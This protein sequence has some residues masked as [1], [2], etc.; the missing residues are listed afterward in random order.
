MAILPSLLLTASLFYTA[1][2]FCVLVTAQRSLLAMTSHSPQDFDAVL[3][4]GPLIISAQVSILLT[5]VVLVQCYTY[6][7]T[8]PGDS[9]WTKTCVAAVALTEVAHFVMLTMLLYLQLTIH[10]GDSSIF[11]RFPPHYAA[12]CFISSMSHAA[13]QSLF[14]HRVKVMTQ[15]PLLWVSA[16]LLLGSMTLGFVGLGGVVASGVASSFRTVNHWFPLVVTLP[17]LGAAGD[18][19]VASSLG[20][21]L[22]K[23]R[24]SAISSRQSIV[25]RLLICVIQTGLLTSLMSVIYVLLVVVYKQTSIW[26]GFSFIVPRIY[27]LSLTTSLNHRETLRQMSDSAIQYNLWP[28]TTTYSGDVVFTKSTTTA[29]SVHVSVE[30]DSQSVSSD[31][32]ACTRTMGRSSASLEKEVVPV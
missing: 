21:C 7:R 11:T 31:S 13:V 3:M 14:I 12:H 29:I 17:I 23:H 26:P 8:F 1:F 16:M 28:M 32:D 25:T 4:V 9:S 18:I 15:I 24:R 5:G 10:W 22:W 30:S 20:F 6:F 2:G 19:L 27:A